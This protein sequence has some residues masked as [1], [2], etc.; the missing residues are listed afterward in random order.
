MGC[1]WAVQSGMCERG[2]LC[3]YELSVCV[4]MLPSVHSNVCFHGCPAGGCGWHCMC[5]L[6]MYVYVY[7]WVFVREWD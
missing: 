1:V 2:Q 6:G 5:V 3:V 4:F 7:V